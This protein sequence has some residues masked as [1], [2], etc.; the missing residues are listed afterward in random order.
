[1]PRFLPG[2]CERVKTRITVKPTQTQALGCRSRIL[3]LLLSFRISFPSP[4]KP[5]FLVSLCVCVFTS[6]FVRHNSCL[7]GFYRL[8]IGGTPRWWRA[9]VQMEMMGRELSKWESFLPPRTGS[10]S[11]G[12]RPRQESS[13]PPRPPVL[14]RCLFIF[15]R[16]PTSR[17]TEK[18]K[19]Q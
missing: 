12:W 2:H 19:R 16:I 4:W 6:V 11:M 7:P 3:P 17:L 1:M 8:D 15:N 13:P 14:Q 5:S 9:C 18:D 10:Y